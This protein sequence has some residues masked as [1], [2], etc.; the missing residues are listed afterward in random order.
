MYADE[1]LLDQARSS[2]VH[3]FW[4][5]VFSEPMALNGDFPPLS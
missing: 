3:S 5:T 4:L 1:E 2:D